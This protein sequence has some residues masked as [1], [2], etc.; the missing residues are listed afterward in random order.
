M[1]SANDPHP[2]R[3]DNM[4]IT[5]ATTNS[6][7]GAQVQPEKRRG[8][9]VRLLLTVAVVLV[10][11][12]TMAV[13]SLALF[14]DSETVG[15]NAFTAGTI[16]ITATPATAVVTMPA[17]APGDQVTNPLTVSNSGS[18]EFR[19]ALTSTTDENVLASELVLTIKTG[20][21]TCTNAGWTATGTQIYSGPL[22]NTT[23]LAIFG[24]AAAGA[25]A[26]DR[27]LAAAGSEILCFNV[28]LPSST[29]VAQG[30]SSTATLN[31]EAEQ[32]ANNP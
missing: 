32:T 17:M 8:R 25:D 23:P 27:V 10:G 31:F 15:S 12:A 22:G 4:T 18:L 30:V 14:T 29:T 11:M 19:Y 21:T 5:E 6:H 26:G 2:T 28:T 16:D 13:T 24:D 1:E 20:V 7:E 3:A 9:P